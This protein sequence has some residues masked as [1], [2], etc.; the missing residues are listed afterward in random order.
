[1]QIAFLLFDGITALDAVGPYEVLS[2]L[3]DAQVRFVAAQVGPQRCD[4]GSLA[5]TAEH[6]L[7]DVP[8]PD[9]VVV[10]GGPGTRELLANAEVLDWIRTAHQTSAWTTSVCTGALLLGAAGLLVGAPA[11]THWRALGDLTA[12][13]AVATG[14]RVVETGKIITAAG[15]S[16]GID[17]ALLLAQRVAGEQ[18]AQAIQLIIEYDPHPPF[19]AG[20][21]ERAPAAVAALARELL[22]APGRDHGARPSQPRQPNPDSVAP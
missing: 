3:P 2:R 19:D 21:P 10:P 16:A 8:S 20:S 14:A 1:M 11:A 12:F 4:M 5:L 13:G 7:A 18:V 15:V 9:I 17:M 22:Q 6:S